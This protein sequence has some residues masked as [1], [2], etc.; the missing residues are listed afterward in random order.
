MPLWKT[1]NHA[2]REIVDGS[3]QIEGFIEGTAQHFRKILSVHV[4]IVLK[5]F[6]SFPFVFFVAPL[7][8]DKILLVVRQYIFQSK[9][10][11][12]DAT[13]LCLSQA[14]INF[15]CEDAKYLPLDLIVAEKKR[16]E[17]LVL[18]QALNQCI[19]N[20]I[21]IRK[22]KIFDG[23]IPRAGFQLVGLQQNISNLQHGFDRH[24]VIIGFSCAA[25]DLRNNLGKPFFFC[26]SQAKALSGRQL[27][28]RLCD[29]VWSR[30]FLC[31]F[32]N[33]IGGLDFTVQI[34]SAA[35]VLDI[36]VSQQ[37]SDEVIFLV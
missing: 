33:K 30:M 7:R 28:H 34:I 37:I 29:K 5:P 10:V 12:H 9:L 23:I 6:D 32:L 22:F 25:V 26:F 8:G 24:I 2:S 27:Y 13:P 20:V 35:W 36:D 3:Q 14:F 31:L 15:V 16:E 17:I 4:P 21:K 19:V 18:L 11:K 1:Y